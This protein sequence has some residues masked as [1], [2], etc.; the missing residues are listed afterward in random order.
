M[1]LGPPVVFLIKQ[2]LN[3]VLLHELNYVFTTAKI[4]RLIIQLL[5]EPR[6]CVLGQVASR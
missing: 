5:T 3:L 4:A 2:I 6:C 1:M